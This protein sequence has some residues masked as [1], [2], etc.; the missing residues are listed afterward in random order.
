[1]NKSILVVVLIAVSSVIALAQGLSG[2]TGIVADPTGAV[3]PG[4]K[5]V[6]LDTKTNRELTATTND[7]G[8]YVFTNVPPGSD[9]RL[10]FTAANF[11]NSSLSGILM[12]PPYTP[13]VVK[14]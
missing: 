2:V 4:A 7:N 6:L 1:M 3:I 14:V 12:M 9:Y 5:V 11:Q 8:V 13:V 10:T